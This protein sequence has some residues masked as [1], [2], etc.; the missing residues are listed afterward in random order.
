MAHIVACLALL[1]AEVYLFTRLSGKAFREVLELPVPKG[2]SPPGNKPM[3]PLPIIATLC[4]LCVTG[5][6]THFISGRS[7]VLPDRPRFA[8]FPAQIGKWQGHASLLDR[9]TEGALH[10]DD[11]ILSDYAR[12]DGKGI[13][14]YVAYY[15]SQHDVKTIHPPLLCLPGGGWNITSLDKIKYRAVEDVVIN[16]LVIEQNSVKQVVYYWYE[17]QGRKIA[18]EYWARWYLLADAITKNRTDG[19]LVRL[20]TPILW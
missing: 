2:N 4:V 3:T 17:E 1:M 18:E 6:T 15:A 14:L 13:N 10:L 12:P 16:R 7:E 20:T 11:Y 19:S 8:T 9:E 5:L